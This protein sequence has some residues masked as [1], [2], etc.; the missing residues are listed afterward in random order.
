MQ[1]RR[2]S[3]PYLVPMVFMMVSTLTAMTL[4]LRDYAA[5]GHT[6]LLVVGGAISVIGLWLVVE[7]VLA[8]TRYARTPP[9]DDLDVD[10]P[11]T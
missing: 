10:L 7:A 8:V 1:R 4:K 3:L 5:A 6:M 9:V 11:G 2:P